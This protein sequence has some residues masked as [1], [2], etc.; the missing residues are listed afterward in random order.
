MLWL[1]LL[2]L[3]W[4]VAEAKCILATAVCVSVYLSVC[5]RIPTLLHYPD[6]TLE[7][8]RGCPLVVHYWADLQ[9]VHGFRCYDNIAPNAKCQRV[10]VLALCLY[11]T[12]GLLQTI[13][14]LQWFD[15]LCWP[16]DRKGIWPVKN[17]SSFPVRFPLG[18][19]GLTRVT[20]VK[21]G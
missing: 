16:G 5:R 15:I 4:D 8:G 19:P 17:C 9:S 1:Q 20:P 11:T 7:N 13:G 12:D 6:V 21:N 14:F 2:H 18:K 10:L 3:A